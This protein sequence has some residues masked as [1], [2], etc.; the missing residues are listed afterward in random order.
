MLHFNYYL[1]QLIVVMFLFYSGYGVYYSIKNKENYM[2]TFLKKRMFALLAEFDIIVFLYFIVGKVIGRKYS[3]KRLLLSLIGWQSVGNSNWYIF[4]ILVMYF[5]T[6][7]SYWL[8]KNRKVLFIVSHV[9]LTAVYIL[10]IMRYKE[11]FWY[12]TVYAYVFG[13]FWGS[14][15]DDI[16][17]LLNKN[18][19]YFTIFLFNLIVYHFSR[20]YSANI[21]LYELMCVSF[22][23]LILLVTRKI[24]FGNAY[25]VF[26]GTNLFP[27]YML[28]RLPMIVLKGKT[29][30]LQNN[31]VFMLYSAIGT[32]VLT[33]A[34]L[35]LKNRI[36]KI[37]AK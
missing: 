15:K 26:L 2:T 30:V 28:Q 5:I 1:D 22:A 14:L 33:Y 21:I 19:L 6:F 29:N 36:K 12:N 27:L 31:T 7:I 25:L 20:K 18:I 11:G 4:S 17:E 35:Y 23:F 8:F 32:I 13:I 34:Y 3:L 9:I 16:D 24:K 37:R 10:I